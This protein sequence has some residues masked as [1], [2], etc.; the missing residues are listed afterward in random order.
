MVEFLYLY[1]KTRINP[2]FCNGI[3]DFSVYAPLLHC[4]LLADSIPSRIPT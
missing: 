3:K 1:I 2:N 4:R